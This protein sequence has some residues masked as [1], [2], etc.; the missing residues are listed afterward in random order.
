MELMQR[1]GFTTIMVDTFICREM[2]VRNWLQNSGLASARQE[3]I[4]HMHLALDG[5]GRRHYNMKIT[6]DDVLIDTKQVILVGSRG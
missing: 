5:A 2:S 1:A 3:A 4:Y 6:A